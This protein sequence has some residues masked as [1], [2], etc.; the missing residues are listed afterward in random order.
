MDPQAAVE[1]DRTMD[2]STTIAIQERAGD[3]ERIL[4]VRSVGITLRKNLRL[5]AQRIGNL[6]TGER[7]GHARIVFPRRRMHFVADPADHVLDLI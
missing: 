5:K 3:D 4:V 6:E 2:R 1:P 7:L